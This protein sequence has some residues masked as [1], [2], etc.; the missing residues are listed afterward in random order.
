MPIVRSRLFNVS[1]QTEQIDYI[2]VVGV[3][4]KGFWSRSPHSCP[5]V[6]LGKSHAPFIS[7]E[8]SLARSCSA[9]LPD[10]VAWRAAPPAACRGEQLKQT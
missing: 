5:L 2:I 9:H 6:P 7:L 3:V 4:K 1:L 10:V 8:S